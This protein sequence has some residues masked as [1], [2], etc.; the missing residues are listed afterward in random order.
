[1]LA[2]GA[3]SPPP[4]PHH[5]PA[6]IAWLVPA[7]IEG[8]GGI[9]TMLQNAAALSSHGHSCDVYVDD[10]TR[11]PRAAADER[12]AGEVRR[13][14]GYEGAVYAGFDLRGEYDLVFAT[15][16]WTAAVAA[17]MPVP[18]K[19]YFVQDFEAWFNPMGDG[20]LMAENSYRLGLPAITIGRWLTH[21]LSGSFG[22]DAT[23]FEFCAD[24]AY[25]PPAP[26][27]AR[28]DA[29]CFIYQPEKPRRCPRL[30]LQ[31]LD[32]VKR[33][34]PQTRVYL[35]GSRSDANRPAFTN[36]GLL[37][38][39]GCNDLYNR[40][41]VGL[42]ISSSNPSRIPFEMMAAGLPVVD[43]H[44]ENNLYDFPPSAILLA[45][46]SPADVAHAVVSL[47]EDSDRARQMGAA[48]LR[49][50]AERP[51]QAGFD[52]F[53]RAV[54]DVLAGRCDRWRRPAAVAPMYGGEAVVASSAEEVSTVDDDAASA[55][56]DVAVARAR[57]A[58][59]E[60]ERSRAW[61]VLNR[62]K[63][64][65]LYRAYANARFGPG[66]D[67]VDPAED[68]RQRLARITSSRTFRLIHAMKRTGVHRVLPR[69]PEA[70]PR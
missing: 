61:R 25:R 31:A 69:S 22:C 28:E 48:G 30:G 46:P 10:R 68:P 44:R 14:F 55:D 58:L 4:P 2:A 18:R 11:A 59:T 20:F 9:R 35:Y 1:M 21:H 6:R 47:L 62:L 50:M 19:A 17:A 51:L 32:I 16:W 43:V 57:A 52:Q 66:W 65:G 15:A 45:R 41:R 13:C 26:G 34:R 42:C 33:F 12:V 64:N 60:L 8:S 39:P 23:W 70:P 29:V 38:V 27:A 37:D 49:F 53:V 5:G 40:C 3:T 54:E 7:M 63:S 67:L 36:V 24:A 56:E